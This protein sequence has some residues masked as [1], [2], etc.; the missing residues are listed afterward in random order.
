[1]KL[2]VELVT[3]II[4]EAFCYSLKMPSSTLECVRSKGQ[5]EHLIMT[6]V[7]NGEV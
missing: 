5:N 7:I 2:Y 1:V 4:I 3:V 6:T